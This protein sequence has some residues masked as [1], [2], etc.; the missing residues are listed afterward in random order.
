VAGARITVRVSQAAFAR[1]MTSARGP[2]VALV[3]SVGRRT[4][5]NAARRAPVDR[6]LL[7]ASLESQIL[8]R[9]QSVTA[10][11][12]SRVKYHPW[13]EIGT[14]IYGPRGRR[15]YPRTKKYLKFRPKGGQGFVFARSVRGVR[16]KRYLT[17]GFRQASPVP[18]RVHR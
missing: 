10:R 4:V 6:G 2:A 16:G 11:I 15:I 7:R 9:Q 3:R 12:G 5:N 18:I 14:G 8:I 17:E 1:H 13:Q